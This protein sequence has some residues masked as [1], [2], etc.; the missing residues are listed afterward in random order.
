MLKRGVFSRRTYQ[1]ELTHET[2][3]A[4]F[5]G[6]PVSFSIQNLKLH[7]WMKRPCIKYTTIR[8]NTIHI[9]Q[10]HP[11]GIITAPGLCSF[12]V[13]LQDKDSQIEV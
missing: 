12:R 8:L 7:S 3:G 4:S 2:I 11:G 13:L 9:R 1:D 10:K 5:L 6:R